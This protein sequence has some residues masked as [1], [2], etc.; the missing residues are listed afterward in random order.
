[1]NSK[2]QRIAGFT[3]LEALVALVVL[4]FVF[5]G[6]WDWFGTALR[7]TNRIEESV[8]LPHAFEQYLDYMSLESLE[9][10]LSGEVQ[11]GQFIFRW[12]ATVNRQ[13]DQEFYRR[14]PNRIVT[15]FDIHVRIFQGQRFVDDISTQLVRQWRDP[16]V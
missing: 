3:L 9:E 10:D 4:S 5:T 6:V 13:S 2:V 1:M 12:S 14:Q 11:V 8:A 15:L 16:N 7:T